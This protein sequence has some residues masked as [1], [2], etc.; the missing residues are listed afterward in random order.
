MGADILYTEGATTRV[1]QR[2]YLKAVI[3]RNYSDTTLDAGLQI[4]FNEDGVWDL[5]EDLDSSSMLDS[6]GVVVC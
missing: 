2:L 4:D 5:V 6:S 3:Q 1:N